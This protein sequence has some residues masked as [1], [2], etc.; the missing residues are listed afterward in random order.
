MMA[1]RG[2]SFWVMSACH[3]WM[4]KDSHQLSTLKASSPPISLASSV[5]FLDHFLKK[6]GLGGCTPCTQLRLVVKPNLVTS[7]LSALL[8]CRVIEGVKSQ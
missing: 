4:N 8:H 1:G 2:E 5:L 7:L 3:E 6:C